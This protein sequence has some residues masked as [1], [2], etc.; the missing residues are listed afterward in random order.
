MEAQLKLRKLHFIGA[1]TIDVMVHSCTLI[2]TLSDTGSR[3]ETTTGVFLYK[4]EVLK[5]FAKFTEKT[6]V[7]ES[8]FKK[9]TG[10]LLQLYYRRN[11]NKGVF[12]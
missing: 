9:D 1:F 3:S 4:K 10:L 6:P 11:S 8:L 5:N 2:G 12:L 7:P